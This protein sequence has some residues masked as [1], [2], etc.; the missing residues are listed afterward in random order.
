MSDID[1][2]SENQTMNVMSESGRES[3]LEAAKNMSNSDNESNHSTIV[4]GQE[5]YDDYHSRVLKLCQNQW[6]SSDKEFVIERMKGGGYNR[7]IGITIVDSQTQEEDRLILRV[8]RWGDDHLDRQ[9]ATLNYIHQHTDIPLP[10][11]VVY[12]ITKQN[13]LESSYSIQKRLSGTNLEDLYPQL[14]HQQRCVVAAEFGRLLLRLQNVTSS[15]AGLITSS[16]KDHKG[17]FVIVPLDIEDKWETTPGYE[18]GEKE[19]PTFDFEAYRKRF[20][21]GT[22]SLEQTTLD[23]FLLQFERWKSLETNDDSFGREIIDG[24]TTVVSHL[25]AQGYLEAPLTLFHGDLMPRNIMVDVKDDKSL[26]FSAIIDWDGASFAP[27]FLSCAPPSWIWDWTQNDEKDE[28]EPKSYD[29][30]TDPESQE[31]KHIFDCTVGPEVVE[32]AYKPEYL[33]ARRLC[34]HAINGMSHSHHFRD[35]MA[36]P[37]DWV[38]LQI[39]ALKPKTW[40]PAQAAR[41]GGLDP[42][43]AIRKWMSRPQKNET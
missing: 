8:P 15:A 9:I 41:K 24:L 5:P 39:L 18:Q 19:T 4:Y 38:E 10:E 34:F 17:D 7:I 42:F 37:K 2:Q 20:H 27:S 23:W 36:V 21:N 28:F 22:A 35:A 16:A 1:T 32:Y 25:N 3:Q 14:S 33:M 43:K 13:P 30:P 40:K 6:P 12:D 31:L 26:S 29:N 11:T